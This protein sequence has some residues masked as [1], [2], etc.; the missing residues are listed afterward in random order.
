MPESMATSF[1]VGKAFLDLQL[2]RFIA[3]G[4]LMAKIDK[5]GGEVET[6]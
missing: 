2:S 5:F 1:S 6:N 4:Q 3:V